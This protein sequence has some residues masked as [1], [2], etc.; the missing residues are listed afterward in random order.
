MEVNKLQISL[1]DLDDLNYQAE[2]EPYDRDF[3][4]NRWYHI[5]VENL[6]QW[7]TSRLEVVKPYLEPN[8]VWLAGGALRTLIHHTEKISDFDLFFNTKEK[9]WQVNEKLKEDGFR[10]VFECPKGELFT[11][12]KRDLKIQCIAKKY[13]KDSIELVDSFDFTVCQAAYDGVSVDIAKRMI[14]SVK[15]K[16]LYV[17]KI[18][19]PV[20][21]INR[22]FKYKQKGY[23]VSEKTIADM[24]MEISD[25]RKF[26]GDHLQMYID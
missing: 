26:T 24:V 5:P 14:K 17:N 25:G 9:L 19:F 23:H 4:V 21:S 18:T 1:D 8:Q 12:K 6:H 2:P 7:R 16:R 3:C 15:L 10:C 11:Y 20:A 22:M 13:Y